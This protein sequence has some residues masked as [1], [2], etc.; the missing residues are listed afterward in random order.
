MIF[1]P[2]IVNSIIVVESYQVG[3]QRSALVLRAYIYVQYYYDPR[4]TEV[5]YPRTTAANSMIARG[6]LQ[7]KNTMSSAEVLYCTVSGVLYVMSWP[8]SAER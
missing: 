1:R 5:Q 8:K 2:N 4:Y 7:W 6:L 3:A